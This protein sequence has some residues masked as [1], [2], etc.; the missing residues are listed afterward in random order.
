MKRIYILPI[1][2]FAL[3]LTACSFG[4]DKSADTKRELF[5]NPHYETDAEVCRVHDLVDGLCQSC[6]ADMPESQGLAFERT[7]DGAGYAVTGLGTCAD[8]QIRIPAYYDGLPVVSII[9]MGESVDVTNVVIGEN[10]TS[11]QSYALSGLTSLK[12]LTVPPSL[13]TLPVNAFAGLPIQSVTLPEGLTEIPY[14]MFQNCGSLRSIHIPSTVTV[15]GDS[16]F[17]NCRLLR[18]INF[19]DGLVSIGDSAF[20]GIVNLYEI[21]LPAS[22]QAV[23]NGAFDKCENL[24]TVR[25][26]GDIATWCT[27]QF[28]MDGNPLV[29]GADFFVGGERVVDLIIPEGVN[30]PGEYTFQGCASIERVVCPESMTE[31]TVG[32]FMSCENIREAV[33]LG[34]L[35]TPGVLHFAGCKSLTDV[36]VSN[37]EGDGVL[38]FGGQF[39][40][41]ATPHY[42]GAWDSENMWYSIQ[43]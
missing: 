40:T 26:S 18:E 19:P 35:T 33:F 28:E 30:K 6:G 12:G 42:R 17:S 27:I 3:F 29:N 11:T 24:K 32:M 9:H 22:L 20:K 31:L 36:Y 43:H 25:Y 8:T 41:N 7:E 14:G 5:V 15:I 2:L 37:S 21:A 39:S 16:A 23:G 34:E 38:L 4:G 10:V 13:T 1:F